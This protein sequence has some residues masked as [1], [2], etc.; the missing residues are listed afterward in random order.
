MGFAR[1]DE[2]GGQAHLEQLSVHPDSAGRGIGRSLL[3]AALDRARSAGYDAMT[4]CTFADV[5]FNAP[6]YASCGF[7]EIAR[8]G[9]ALAALRTREAQLGLDGLGRRVAMQRRL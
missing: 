7:E 9:P 8:P 1:V 6:F 5:P 3:A 2:V 4:L